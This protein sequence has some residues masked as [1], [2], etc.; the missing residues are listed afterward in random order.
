MENAI[1]H[2]WSLCK[3]RSIIFILSDFITTE[4]EYSLRI[5]SRKHDV[6]AV[7]INDPA[8]L[9]LTDSGILNLQDPETGD[10]ITINT[11]NKKLR[12]L[13]KE[14]IER[15]SDELSDT[16]KRMNVDLVCLHTNKPYIYDLMKFFKARTKRR[17]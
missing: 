6:V 2:I 12:K 4:Y 7:K 15:Q 5:L 1:K 14:T 13:Y 3:K 10:I 16:F 9:A 8:E 11:S 17:K